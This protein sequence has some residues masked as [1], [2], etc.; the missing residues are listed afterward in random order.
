MDFLLVGLKRL[1]PIAC[2]LI[3]HSAFAANYFNWNADGTSTS[4]GG[5]RMSSASIDTSVKHSGTGSMRY[6]IADN[7][8]EQI[9]CTSLSQ[10]NLGFTWD[11]GKTLYYRFWMKIDPGFGWGSRHKMKAMRL[12]EN[13]SPALT[14][15]LDSGSIFLEECP[16]CTNASQLRISYDFRPS[17]PND[18]TNWHEYIVALTFQSGPSSTDAKLELFVDGKSQGSVG[19]FRMRSC[20]GGCS[21]VTT[22]T[23]GNAFAQAFYTQLCSPGSSNCGSGGRMWFDDFSVDD[24]F[25]SVVGS[26]ATSM[27]SPKPMPPSLLPIE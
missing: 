7:G 13:G 10:T 8:D 4:R 18:V 5:C 21:S 11:S 16:G 1:I 15:Y 9:G 20:S 27:A 12:L 6:D 23:W 24:T 26:S 19:G 14:P 3:W 17:G 2:C 25:N 22:A